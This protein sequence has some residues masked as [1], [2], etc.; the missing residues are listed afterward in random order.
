MAKNIFASVRLLYHDHRF[1]LDVS[2][3]AGHP[4]SAGPDHSDTPN[5]TYQTEAKNYDKLLSAAKHLAQTGPTFD[6]FFHVDADK[7]LLYSATV[8]CDR[9]KGHETLVLDILSDTEKADVYIS[10]AGKIQA[11]ET[12]IDLAFGGMLERC[13]DCNPSALPLTPEHR[14]L[15]EQYRDIPNIAEEG[16]RLFPTFKV[17]H[18]A[19]FAFRKSD[20]RTMRHLAATPWSAVCEQYGL[21]AEERFPFFLDIPMDDG[22]SMRVEYKSI[23]ADKPLQPLLSL[24]NPAD[25]CVGT[26]VFSDPAHLLGEYEFELDS[27]IYAVELYPALEQTRVEQISE[28]QDIPGYTPEWHAHIVEAAASAFEM[29]GAEWEWEAE[30]AFIWATENMTTG[31]HDFPPALY[32]ALV[33]DVDERCVEIRK[34]LEYRLSEV[35]ARTAKQ[36]QTETA[37]RQNRQSR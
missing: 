6:M 35:K 36:S 33:K 1:D 30:D 32:D 24:F 22:F 26:Q 37:L 10:V 25:N 20:L 14:A 4:V 19:D 31:P 9:S 18:E 34:T 28:E 5:Y 13:M 16:K 23:S 3:Q 27:D 12:A 2:A 7:E 8:R 11:V 17:I 29:H 15:M 21:K